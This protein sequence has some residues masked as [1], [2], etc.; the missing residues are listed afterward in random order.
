MVIQAGE[1]QIIQDRQLILPNKILQSTID[2]AE[3]NGELSQ[4]IFII[5]E[6]RKEKDNAHGFTKTL[7]SS[8]VRLYQILSVDIDDNIHLVKDGKIKQKY[9]RRQM[10]STS[11][12]NFASHTT[13]V[14]YT[15]IIFPEK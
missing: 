10:A 1:P 3:T 8:T 6:D 15:N 12:R 5:N 11:A 13:A 2:I 4:N 7:Y 9:K 14:P